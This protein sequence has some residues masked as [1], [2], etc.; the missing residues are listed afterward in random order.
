MADLSGIL[1][2]MKGEVKWHYDEGTYTSVGETSFSQEVVSEIDGITICMSREKV[3]TDT[4]E[5]I[6]FSVYLARDG[7][8]FCESQVDVYSLDEL[9][10]DFEKEKDFSFSSDEDID[11]FNFDGI[12]ESFDFISERCRQCSD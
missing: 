3:Q 10:I 4:E 9:G 11:Q 8:S 2:E 7:K 6:N 12:M 1:F 5:I